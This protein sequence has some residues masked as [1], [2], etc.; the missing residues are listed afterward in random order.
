[1]NPPQ[2]VLTQFTLVAL[3]LL[4]CGCAGGPTK[5]YYNP[6]V[7]GAKFK[8]PVTMNRVEDVGSERVRLVNAG[9]TLVGSTVYAGKH[10]KAVELKAQ[11]KRAGANHVVYS[12]DFHPNPPGSWNFRFGQGFG[13]GGSGGGYH[14]VQIVFLGK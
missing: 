14:N 3:S 1:M 8:G 13:S 7:V 12:S 9:Y 11:A 6:T 10:P 2:K 5:E 4:L